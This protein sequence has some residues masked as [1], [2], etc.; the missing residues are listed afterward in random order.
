M[1]LSRFLGVMAVTAATLV[2]GCQDHSKAE[3][4]QRLADGTAKGEDYFGLCATAF[5]SEKGERAE[6]QGANLAYGLEPTTSPSGQ[7]PTTVYCPVRMKSGEFFL[8]TFRLACADEDNPSCA[9]DAAFLPTGR[10]DTSS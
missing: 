1:N 3:R 6:L 9:A 4:A 8:M 5:I 2:A 10:Y 7:R